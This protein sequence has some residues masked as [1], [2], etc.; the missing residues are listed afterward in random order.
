MIYEPTRLDGETREAYLERFRRLNEPA[1]TMLDADEW[2]QV[3]HHVSTCDLPETS[4]RWLDLGREAGFSKATEVFVDPTGFY[5]LY[6][7]DR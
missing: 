2:A 3:Y 5:R 4:D 6:R 1:W 7:Y